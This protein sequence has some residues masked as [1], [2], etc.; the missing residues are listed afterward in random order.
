MTS[1]PQQKQIWIIQFSPTR[2][3][4]MTGPDGEVVECSNSFDRS[5]PKKFS[6]IAFDK[7]AEEVKHDYN[8]TLADW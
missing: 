5:V 7:G 3:F 8:G 6:K 2:G 1:L 4:F